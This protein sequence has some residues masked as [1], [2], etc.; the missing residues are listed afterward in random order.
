MEATMKLII[1]KAQKNVKPKVAKSLTSVGVVIDQD[2]AEGGLMELESE[3]KKI[4]LDMRCDFIDIGPEVSNTLVVISKRKITDQ[5]FE[6]IREEKIKEWEK[7]FD[8][9]NESL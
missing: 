8:E 9:N 4:G 2:N 5:E 6:K 7:L 3:L 1:K